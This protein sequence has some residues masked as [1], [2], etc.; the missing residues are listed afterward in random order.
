MK[1]LTLLIVLSLSILMPE[2]V[3][4]QSKKFY[5]R[6]TALIYYDFAIDGAL[7]QRFEAYANLFRPCKEAKRNPIKNQLLYTSWDMIREAME[8][9]TGM[10]IVPIDAY[11]N[12]FTYDDYGF[13]N[14]GINKALKKGSSKYYLRFDISLKPTPTPVYTTS[15][16]P[17]SLAM[18]LTAEQILPIL[19]IDV[20]IYPDKGVLPTS[21]STITVKAQQPFE[22]NEAL[23]DGFVN[24]KDTVSAPPANIYSMFKEAIVQLG[25]SIFAG[26]R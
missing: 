4:A 10:L 21:K 15:T 26:I 1:R 12:R 9:Q 20:T 2:T 18:A 24:D 11:G 6:E 5:K 3:Q 19:T 14:M 17:D 16:K 8:E 25:G 22:V 23:F 13:P 7:M